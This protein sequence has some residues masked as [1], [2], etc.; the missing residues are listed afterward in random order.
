MANKTVT[1]TKHSANEDVVLNEGRVNEG[2]INQGSVGTGCADVDKTLAMLDDALGGALLG[3]LKDEVPTIEP[4]DV[5]V[6][7]EHE[8]EIT[9]LTDSDYDVSPV[10]VENI[11]PESNSRAEEQLKPVAKSWF[12]KLTAKM[13]KRAS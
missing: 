4:E 12:S 7:Q 10:P 1:Y 9:H 6:V 11:V 5:I 13:T 3:G 8:Q 2:L